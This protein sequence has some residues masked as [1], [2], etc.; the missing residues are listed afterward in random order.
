[1]NS[2]FA[3]G[4]DVGGTNTEFGLV[5][6][7]GVVKYKNELKTSLFN[8]A[9]SLVDAIF[10]EV[11]DAI[12]SFGG[13]DN[14]SG[15]GIGAPNGN[16]FTGCIEYAPN[17]SWKGVV[18]IAEL[19]SKK[20]NT[21]SYLTN[22]A[23]AAAIGEKIYG[24]AK[25]LSDF[26][27]ITLG[28]GIGSG[29]FINNELI[30]GANGL[31]GEFGHFRVVREGRECGCKR[32]GCLETY[33]SATGVV[34]SI[35]LLESVNKTISKIFKINKPQASDVFNLAKNGDLFCQEI[36]DYTAKILGESL[37]DFACFSNPQAY[38]LFGG[39]SQSGECFRKKVEEN[40]EKNLLSIYKGIEVKT[41]ELHGENAAILGASSLV[42]SIN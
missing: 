15:I 6:N 25:D 8:N 10:F 27:S 32:K 2:K 13:Q 28:T 4:I 41:S 12:Q 16:F 40:M 1:M 38:I 3:L 5:D 31:A 37:A 34:R 21:S 36:I 9:S 26:V 24:A 22:D 30:Y 29:I 39:I 42:W 14:L 35:E 17:L 19:F 33:A 7:V 11:S 18:P 23:N 20:F